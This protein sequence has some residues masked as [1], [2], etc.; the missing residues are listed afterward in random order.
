MRLSTIARGHHPQCP[1]NDSYGIQ[2]RQEN[3][4]YAVINIYNR[5]QNLGTSTASVPRTHSSLP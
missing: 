5:V 1:L 4:H 2:A 3:F